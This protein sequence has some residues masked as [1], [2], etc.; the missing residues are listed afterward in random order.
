[1]KLSDGS[2]IP[3]NRHADDAEIDRRIAQFHAPYHTAIAAMV[4][5][6]RDAGRVPILISLHSF[7][8]VWKTTPRPWEIGV[9]WDRDGRLAQPLMNRLAG[10]GFVVGDNEPY[11]GALE[12]D[13]LN[14]HGTKNG[15]PHVL[16]EIRQDLIGTEPAAQ[17]MAERLAPILEAAL[18]D[19][20]QMS[21]KTTHS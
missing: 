15:L 13:T 4:A 5:R 3:G 10:A 6:L 7:T 17:A 21:R 14:R 12:N 19:M 2:V 9:L 1:M 8:P 20:G 18:A 16:I 11:S